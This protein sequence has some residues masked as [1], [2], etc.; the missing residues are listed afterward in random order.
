[1]GRTL[2]IAQRPESPIPSHYTWSFPGSPVNVRL[3]LDVVGRLQKQLEHPGETLGEQGV[4][5]GRAVAQ[6]TEIEHFTTIP[7]SQPFAIQDAAASIQPD[8]LQPV[9]YYRIHRE[10]TLRLND[11][12]MALAQNV[13]SEPNQVVLLIQPDETSPATATFFFWDEGRMCGDFPFLEFPFDSA[14]LAI[15]ERQ[16]IQAVQK[17]SSAKSQQVEIDIPAGQPL[18][19]KPP[20]SSK[21]ITLSLL[22]AFLVTLSLATVVALRFLP[23]RSMPQVPTSISLPEA[24]RIPLGLQAERQNGDL[25][26]TWNREAIAVR[27]ATTGVLSIEDGQTHR[28]IMLG[29]AQV[30]NGSILYAPTTDQIQLQLSIQGPDPI[31]ESVI[32]VLPKSGA[33]PQVQTFADKQV[34]VIP[35]PNSKPLAP[36]TPS[37]APTKPFVLPPRRHDIGKPTTPVLPDDPPAISS[38]T[39]AAFIAPRLPD[40][41][42]L[43][44]PAVTGKPVPP[45]ASSAVQP[46][47][48]SPTAPTAPLKPT[49]A[50]PIYYPPVAVASVT[51][52]YPSALRSMGLPV[53]LI[54]LKVSIDETGKVVKAQALPLKA[55]TPQIMIQ[56]A[57]DAVRLWK[58]KPER[59]GN[60]SVPSEM[61]LQFAFKSPE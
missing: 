45:Q 14:L 26:L 46:L 47:P 9:G 10:T 19:L 42:A 34:P 15:A 4:L 59:K 52:T 16:K 22:T 53:K 7:D 30:R 37:N 11:H 17:K 38:Q 25:K 48:L 2:A 35:A 24:S 27:N 43:P 28:E 58:F 61:V 33:D 12:D 5:W 40:P 21:L 39:A 6:I 31:S 18:R 56:A 51:P 1:M 60:Q 3:S 54:E 8:A 50:D 20:A 23:Q 41:A 29:P 36:A 55:W 44:R 49:P 13:F 32:V 57:L